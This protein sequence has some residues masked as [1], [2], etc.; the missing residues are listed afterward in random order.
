MRAPSDVAT[1]TRLTYEDKAIS[2][3]ATMRTLLTIAYAIVFFCAGAQAQEALRPCRQLKDDAE[4]L[5]CYDRL[6][7]S[8]SSSATGTQAES[9]QG[10][11]GI[12]ELRDEKSPLDD[13]PVVSAQLPSTDGKAYLLMRCKDRKTEVAVN[14]W[15]FIKCGAGVRVTYRIDQ[16]QAV[17]SPWNSHSSCYLALAPSPI[18]FIQALTDQGKVYFRMW[19]HH[20]A[21]HDA[22]FNVGK[23]SEIRSRLAEACNWDGAAKG[24]GAPVPNAATPAVSP[25]A[26]PPK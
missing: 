17:D 10:G 22:S 26:A 14:K 4:R 1:R 15:G 9:K 11:D 5:K 20:D 6:D 3:V 2:S 24:V 16:G 18:P 7:A 19:D 13:S 25:R 21:P 23:I 12:W 8:S